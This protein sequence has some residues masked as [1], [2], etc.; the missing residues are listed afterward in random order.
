MSANQDNETVKNCI[1]WQLS[2]DATSSIYTAPAKYDKAKIGCDCTICLHVQK[3]LDNETVKNC[4]C[5]QL[6]IDAT[7]SI[8]TAPAKY[9]KAK[10]G[11]DCTIL[12][13]S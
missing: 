2:I 3:G 11:C 6:S 9:D 5:W 10:I 12:P 1:C 8:Y 4:I 13:V 7:S